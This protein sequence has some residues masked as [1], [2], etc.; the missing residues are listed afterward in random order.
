MFFDLDKA[1]HGKTIEKNKIRNCENPGTYGKPGEPR[2]SGNPEYH[3]I[4][5]NPEKRE[6]EEGER[7]VEEPFS[8]KQTESPNE[9]KTDFSKL[10]DG[11][12]CGICRR[13]SRDFDDLR[14]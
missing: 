5:G 4:W 8:T 14:I 2:K 7:G 13:Q 12:S 10:H 1:K 9:S 3:E 6:S 11:F